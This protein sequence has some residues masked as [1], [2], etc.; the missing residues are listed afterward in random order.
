MRNEW[1]PKWVGSAQPR[2]QRKYRFNAPLHVRHKFLAAPLSKELR[3]QLRIRHIAVRKGDEVEVMR[4]QFKKSK[5][6]VDRVS[7]RT[8]KVYIDT[9]K[10]KKAGGAEVLRPVDPSNVRITKLLLDDKERKAAVQRAARTAA[11]AKPMKGKEAK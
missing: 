5:G 9:V 1:S 8:A 2:K 4:G 11:P 7:L 10:V 3:A 6:V